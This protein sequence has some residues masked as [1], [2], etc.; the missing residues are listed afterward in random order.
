VNDK[1]S[2]TGDPV[3]ANKAY[4]VW[5]RLVSPAENANPSAFTHTI[6]FRGPTLF[7]RTTDKGVTWSTGRIIFDP[8]EKDQTIGNQIV[9]P[10][11]GSASGVRIDWTSLLTNKGG[12]CLF[13][14][15]GQHYGGSQT[16][17]APLIRSTDGGNTW[18]DAL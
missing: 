15:G 18:S 14:H 7:S 16:L 5:D 8:G 12:K 9:V 6:A 11:A 13:T 4:A 1:E 3:S 17:S 2:V 10:T